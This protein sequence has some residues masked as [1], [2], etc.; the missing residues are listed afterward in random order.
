M[1]QYREILRLT[2]Q[3]MSKKG[4]AAGSSSLKV[5]RNISSR[6]DHLLKISLSLLHKT[7]LYH[8]L[9][10]NKHSTHSDAT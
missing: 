3:G 2:S 4:I 7:I 10:T 1:T 8:I 5:M 6:G 9:Y